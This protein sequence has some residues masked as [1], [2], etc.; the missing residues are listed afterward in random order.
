M[1]THV[2]HAPGEPCTARCTRK[3]K[4]ADGT[5]LRAPV[6][7]QDPSTATLTLTPAGRRALR[8]SRRTRARVVYAAV[9]MSAFGLGTLFG[10]VLQ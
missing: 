8:Q 1:T 6:L 5:R 7:V 10:L 3:I 4:G 9:F 2:Q